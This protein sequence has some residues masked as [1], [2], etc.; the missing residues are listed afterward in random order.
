MDT[1]L[2]ICIISD[3]FL[4]AATGVGTHVQ[5]IGKELARRGHKIAVLTSR[6]PGEQEIEHWEGVTVYRAFTLKV[7]GFYQALPSKTTIKRIL[8]QVK[9]DL[10]HHHYLSIL[11]K[12]TYNVARAMGIPQIYTYHMT[13][14]HLTQ[15]FFMRPFRGLISRQIV[16][17]CNRF[18][19]I[20]CPSA[21]LSKQLPGMGIHAPV[22][23]IS[24]P[25]V[26]DDTASVQPASRGPEFTI[27][28]AGRFEPEKNV[29]FLLQAFKLLLNQLPDATLWLAGR[30]S[31]RETLER[32][33]AELGISNRV[34][35][36]GF[37]DHPSLAS[38]YAA[39]DVFVLPALVEVQPLVAMEAMW[40]GR[41]VIVT[42]AIVAATEMV[43]QGVNGYIVDP[44][45]AEDLAERLATLAA[46]PTL[47][48]SQGEASRRRANA[49]RPELVVDELEATYRN[50]VASKASEQK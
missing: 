26:F 8:E 18:T 7:A 12:R 46:D 39:C 25:V 19:Q 4:P 2:S 48:A 32:Q 34:Q 20:L 43:E 42:R 47:R 29:S 50:I 22:R 40:F 13:V 24:N 49:Y 9:P 3:D 27:L 15:P 31:L 28:F 11:L 21:S 10:V 5:L 6:R 38:R 41:P 44:E 1:P 16:D 33:A 14:D 23:Y 45:S 35:F 30:G 36:L 17:S 37:L